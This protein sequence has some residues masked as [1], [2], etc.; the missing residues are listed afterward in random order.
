VID[1]IYRP[2]NE[3]VNFVR[4]GRWSDGSRC[5]NKDGGHRAILSGVAG[6]DETSLA[7]RWSPSLLFSRQ[8]ISNQRLCKI[9]RIIAVQC[10]SK[11]SQVGYIIVRSEAWLNLAHLITITT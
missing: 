6:C 2:E 11:K 3:V 4:R 1:L 7:R 9:V 5:N 10:Y 8:R